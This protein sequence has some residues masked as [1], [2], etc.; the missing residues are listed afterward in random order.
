VWSYAAIGTA[1][2]SGESIGG[3]CFDRLRSQKG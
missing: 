3:I 2:N 1:A